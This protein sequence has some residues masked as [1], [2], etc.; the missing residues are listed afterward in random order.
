MTEKILGIVLCGRMK[1]YKLFS[2]LFIAS[3]TLG[4]DWRYLQIMVDRKSLGL[5]KAEKFQ[6]ESALA[7]PKLFAFKGSSALANPKLLALPLDDF[8]F[9]PNS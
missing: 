1:P 7:N 2:G 6:R 3:G 9:F 5:A 8:F 4:I